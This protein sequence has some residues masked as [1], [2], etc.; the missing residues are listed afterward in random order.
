MTAA[1]I[2]LEEIELNIQHA[3][4]TG[5]TSP[6][7]A[8][9]LT[10][11]HSTFLAMAALCALF[12][13]KG[14][15]GVSLHTLRARC[16]LSGSRS[17][18]GNVVPQLCYSVQIVSHRLVKCTVQGRASDSRYASTESSQEYVRS[19]ECDRGPVGSE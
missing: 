2:G 14:Q 8:L 10:T 17:T 5:G 1:T 12:V 13:S 11:Q 3:S 18:S 16:L 4:D 15:V 7:T 6:S 9:G 19:R